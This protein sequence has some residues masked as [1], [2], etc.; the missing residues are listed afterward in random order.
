MMLTAARMRQIG[1]G[2]LLAVCILAFTVL[3]LSVHAVQNEVVLAE[4]RIIALKQETLLLETEFESRANQRQLAHWNRVEFGYQSP[5][6]DQYIDSRHE[7]AALGEPRGPDAPSPVRFARADLAA[8][9]P[10]LAAGIAERAMVSPI[11]GAPISA[12]A[13]EEGS[14]GEFSD[15]FEEFMLDLG[16]RGQG[17]QGGA[18]RVREASLAAGPL[19]GNSPE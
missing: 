1:W 8:L 17:G 18:V 5:R 19:P 11:S 9:D 16:P 3:S 6:A 2:A 4:R 12:G 10:A 15:A 14:M 7:L 13:G